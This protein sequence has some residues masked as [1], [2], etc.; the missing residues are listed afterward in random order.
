MQHSSLCSRL[1]GGFDLSPLLHKGKISNPLQRKP[2]PCYYG[3]SRT[4]V[5]TEKDISCVETFILNLALHLVDKKVNRNVR[6]PYNRCLVCARS[7]AST[8]RQALICVCGFGGRST[9]GC[10]GEQFT[11]GPFRPPLRPLD[12]LGPY[13]PPL[14]C[15]NIRALSIYERAVIVLH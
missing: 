2:S 12:P 15:A 6:Q 11:A 7:E 14:Y 4:Q 13:L 10:A 9:P 1:G 3:F 8:G 5:E